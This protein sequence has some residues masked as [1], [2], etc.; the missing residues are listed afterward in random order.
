VAETFTFLTVISLLNILACGCGY[1]QES[2]PTREYQIRASL[3]FNFIQF[4]TWPADVS[5]PNTLNICLLGP[6]YYGAALSA[7]E[8]EIVQ[9]KEIVVKRLG[10]DLPGSD[11]DCRVMI[12]QYGAA[13][14]EKALE[15]AR[16][17]SLLTIGD[18]PDFL[19]KGGIIS[20]LLLKEKIVFD[21]NR[22]AAHASNV[23]LSSKL[24]RVARTVKE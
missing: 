11:L 1:A 18:T 15:E 17:H 6:D 22:A 7:L 10:G 24:L 5:E 2:R 14:T 8:R 12:I 23:E 16:Q 4:T 21:I 9:G 20:I 13:D 3:I 19:D